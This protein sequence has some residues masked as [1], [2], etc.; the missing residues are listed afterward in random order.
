MGDKKVKEKNLLLD[1]RKRILAQLLLK[2]ALKINKKLEMIYK[3]NHLKIKI[4]MGNIH[5][6]QNKKIL[7]KRKIKSFHLKDLKEIQINNKI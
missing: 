2:L 7:L 4:K 5:R 3:Q 1:Y 6:N